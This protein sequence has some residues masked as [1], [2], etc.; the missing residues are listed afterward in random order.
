MY[1]PSPRVK[2]RCQD[3]P[4]HNSLLSIFHFSLRRT[5]FTQKILRPRQGNIFLR[6]GRKFFL[7]DKPQEGGSGRMK[8]LDVPPVKPSALLSLTAQSLIWLFVLFRQLR[9][10]CPIALKRLFSEDCDTL[11]P[12]TCK[13]LRPHER[14]IKGIIYLFTANKYIIPNISSILF[15]PL[16]NIWY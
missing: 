11:L 15:N 9:T 8:K 6:C 3:S 12:F 7:T 16:N 2:L 14:K 10:I 4:N 13:I 1:N 5:D